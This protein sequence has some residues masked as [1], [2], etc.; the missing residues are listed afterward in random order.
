MAEANLLKNG[1]LA[2]LNLLLERKFVVSDTVHNAMVDL[3]E[4]TKE[5]KRVKALPVFLTH[6][7]I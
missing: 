5:F 6:I 3:W 7:F 1:K 4:I 2:T